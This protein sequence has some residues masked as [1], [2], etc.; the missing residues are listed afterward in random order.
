[1]KSVKRKKDNDKVAT[2]KSIQKRDGSIAPFD[3]QK[4]VKEAGVG[5]YLGA[6]LSLLR[7]YN[8]IQNLQDSFQWMSRTFSEPNCADLDFDD[9][10]DKAK[11]SASLRNCEFIQVDD[12]H[13]GRIERF[14]PRCI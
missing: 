11:D 1:M 6:I 7:A 3:V 9:I 4:I 10:I 13:D 12:N 2:V 5:K 14:I 8:H